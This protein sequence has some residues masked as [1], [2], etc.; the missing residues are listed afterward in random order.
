[1]I[2]FLI[3]QKQMCLSFKEKKIEGSLRCSLKTESENEDGFKYWCSKE[4]P[5]LLQLV[6]KLIHD[7]EPTVSF[8]ST[9]KH[10]RENNPSR[11][12]S[13]SKTVSQ[14]VGCSPPRFWWHKSC[15]GLVMPRSRTSEA[16]EKNHWKKKGLRASRVKWQLNFRIAVLVSDSQNWRWAGAYEWRKESRRE[17]KYILFIY[18]YDIK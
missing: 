18:A 17:N 5:Y 7:H 13:Y 4:G 1:M 3:S 14:R 16:W 10:K 15:E 6:L 2:Y 8:K 12:I 9:F 11:W